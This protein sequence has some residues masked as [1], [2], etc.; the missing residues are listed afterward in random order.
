VQRYTHI[1]DDP[2]VDEA[3]WRSSFD[4]C[5]LRSDRERVTVYIVAPPDRMTVWAPLWRIWLGSLIRE[6]A[7]AGTH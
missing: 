7:N 6:V 3:T 2:M 1:F 4:P 5:R